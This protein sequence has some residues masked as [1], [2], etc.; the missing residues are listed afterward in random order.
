MLTSARGSGNTP[1]LSSSSVFHSASLLLSASRCS[2]SRSKRH[3]ARTTS[4]RTSWSG[5]RNKGSGCPTGSPRI[6]PSAI[7]V[8]KVAV[9]SRS[10]KRAPAI[11]VKHGDCESPYHSGSSVPSVPVPAPIT[12]LLWPPPKPAFRTH[13][14]ATWYP[15]FGVKQIVIS[16][17]P[18]FLESK[19]SGRCAPW[20]MHTTARSGPIVVGTTKL[21]VSLDVSKQDWLAANRFGTNPVGKPGTI[22]VVVVPSIGL[23]RRRQISPLKLPKTPSW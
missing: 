17:E 6:G 16:V 19:R 2:I 22:V 20:N 5:V 15:P 4:W 14:A 18:S 23:T 12:G 3:I 11:F 7:T 9:P 8:S 1:L 13:S 10:R 21:A